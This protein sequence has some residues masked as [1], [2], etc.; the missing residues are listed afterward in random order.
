MKV[1][2]VRRGR[3]VDRDARRG[4]DRRSPVKRGR[5][6]WWRVALALFFL[7][8]M[9]SARTSDLRAQ[10]G[11]EIRFER[12]SL[13]QG[14]SQGSVNCLLQDRRGF[15][16]VGTR[17]GL[18]RFDGYTFKVYRHDPQDPTSLSSNGILA[19]LEDRAGT[20]WMAAGRGGLCRYDRLNDR[21]SCDKLDPRQSR[22]PSGDDFVALLEDRA[23]TIWV[24]TRDGGVCRYDHDRRTYDCDKHDPQ[25]PRSLSSN[26]VEALAEDRAG[27]IW[28][29][30]VGGG[31]CRYDPRSKD[32][33]CYRHDPQRPGSLSSDDVMALLV[34]RAGTVWVGGI[35]SGLCRYDRE[36]DRFVCIKRDPRQAGGLSDDDVRTLYED[37]AGTLWVGT[38]G[39]GLCRYDRD[40]Q[41]FTVYKSDPRDAQSLSSDEVRAIREDRAG[42][43]WVGTQGGGLCRF[44]PRGENFITYRHDP[45]QPHSLSGDDVRAVYED[46]TGAIWVGSVNGGLCRYERGPDR[47]GGSFTCFGHDPRRAGSLSSDDVRAVYEDHAGTLWVGTNGGGLCRYDRRRQSFTCLKYDPH[48][49]GSLSNNAIRAL[50]ED[51]TGTF[52]VGT[53]EGGLCRY[54]RDRGEFALYKHDPQ[55]PKSLSGNGVRALY[56]DRR[57]TLW[58][59][60]DNGLCRYDRERGEFAC[61]QHDPQNPK[62]LSNSG[63]WAI[64]EDRAGTI[65]VG[66]SGGG[67][68]RFDQATETFQAFGE[69]EGL[70]S[71]TVYSIAGDERGRLWLGTNH[72]IYRFNP[73]T[74]VFRNYDVNDN[75]PNNE[76]N[77]GA[78]LKTR[79]GEMFFGGV[80]GLTRFDPER[81]LENTAGPPVIITAFR[82]FNQPVRLQ[83]SIT[84]TQGIEL[85]Y[86]DNFI[87]FE[88]AALNL[89]DP[90]KNRYRYQLEGFDADWIEAGTQRLATYTNLDAGTYHFKVIAANADGVWNTEGARLRL[91][92]RPPF[93][94][95]WWFRLL[96]LVSLA[97]LA[98][99]G[100]R[101]RVTRLKRAHTEQQA[102]SR[103]LIESQE[104]ERKRI[105]AELHD[106]LGQ[107]L[108]VIKNRAQLSLKQSADG[109][110]I[111]G[112][113]T[114]I[115]TAS[116]Q[117]IQELKDVSYNL[118][119]YLLDRLGLTLAL[120]SMLNKAFATEQY[121]LAAEIEGVDGLLA[122]ESEIHLYRVIQECANNIIKHAE[123]S[124]VRV[125]IRKEAGALTLTITDNGKGF[126]PAGSRAAELNT[127]GFGLAGMTER[128]RLLGGTHT[129]D[130]APGQGTT[131]T[132]KLTIP[133]EKL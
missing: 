83:P 41:S 18:N 126:T 16:W 46:R 128:V 96:A 127:R 43:M 21:F 113:L 101:W 125:T 12:L 110:G 42:T 17:E 7:T 130:S 48:K 1:S 13:E 59:G 133:E 14:L 120:K 84:E 132:I 111:E 11:R 89:F 25:Q 68:N 54:D 52:W 95:A 62:S 64:Y 87:S 77:Q 99:I 74:N 58:V 86:R 30:T 117:A 92:V 10:E 57:G 44:N 72:S 109:N 67:L 129:V 98:F 88:Y 106:G 20:L 4:G 85:S 55:N 33:A 66:T 124:E 24:G 97:G 6:K 47:G 76:F 82:K 23:G 50:L 94:R 80:V 29:G 90:E 53:R 61:Y 114:A 81:M 36:R 39:G 91:I 73:T 9:M 75:L 100:Y 8:A 31:L 49:L 122:K 103:R 56:E 118:R 69:G 32:Y 115:S 131:V 2:N 19:I 37:R 60:T 22:S 26:N 107:S 34:D 78:A 15:L 119:P 51:H 123:A 5:R 3:A 71:D 28:V 38:R 65:W 45:R 116:S 102:F 108:I 112:Q 79:S 27:M 35:D 105:A 93:W 121:H 63:V 70:T 40:R 104:T